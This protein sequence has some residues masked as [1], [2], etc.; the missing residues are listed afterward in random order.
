MQLKMPRTRKQAE[1]LLPE[2]ASQ[3]RKSQKKERKIKKAW[4]NPMLTNTNPPKMRKKYRN[5]IKS[6]KIKKKISKK[7]QLSLMIGKML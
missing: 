3:K 7:K 2:N 5:L 1:V 4:H 6:R